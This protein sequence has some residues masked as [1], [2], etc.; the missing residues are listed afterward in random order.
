MSA[1][2]FSLLTAALY[3]FISIFTSLLY[4]KLFFSKSHYNFILSFAFGVLLATVFFSIMP[5]AIENLS[6]NLIITYFVA[7]FLTFL[8]LENFIH[9]NHCKKGEKNDKKNTEKHCHRGLLNVVGDTVHSFIEGIGIAVAYITSIPIGISLT[10]ASI[11][12]EI[13]KEIGDYA[14]LLKAKHNL[15][16]ATKLNLLASLSIIPG[17]LLPFIFFDY[18]ENYHYLKPA[19]LTFLA[20]MFIY[21]AFKDIYPSLAHNNSTINIIQLMFVFLGIMFIMGL[22][23]TVHNY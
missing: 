18:Y 22:E 10:I 11:F 8:L 9:H 1:L 20:G 5:Y 17:V 7:G 2:F 14:V 23:F 13:P 15:A 6:I 19:I 16:K 21:I 4:K 12:H 3:V